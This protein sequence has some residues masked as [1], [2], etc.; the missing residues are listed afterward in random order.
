[1]S[2]QRP[3]CETMSTDEATISKMREIVAIVE[4]LERKGFCTKQELY[5][6][7]TEFRRKNPMP[8]FLKP[9][10]LSRISSLKPRTRSSTTFWSC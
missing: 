8:A 5:E 1:M 10:S 2:E 9:P 3:K 6:I 7:I 4:V